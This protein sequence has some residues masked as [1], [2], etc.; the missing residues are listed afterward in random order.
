MATADGPSPDDH[1]GG[2]YWHLASPSVNVSLLHTTTSSVVADEEQVAELAARELKLDRLVAAPPA[3]FARTQNLHEASIAV[4][5]SDSPQVVTA[6]GPPRSGSSESEGSW[7]GPYSSP[8]DSPLAGAIGGFGPTVS[9]ES[10]N[11]CESDDLG[12]S[13]VRLPPLG[14]RMPHFRSSSNESEGPPSRT[15]SQEA[16]RVLVPSTRQPYLRAGDYVRVGLFIDVVCLCPCRL[17]RQRATRSCMAMAMAM[18]MMSCRG[19]SCPVFVPRP[20]CCTPCSPADCVHVD[21]GAK[22]G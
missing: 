4:P 21:Q 1:F 15:T 22:V 3:E 5:L 10:F 7:C 19:S 9:A 14:I 11:S 17:R 2:R 12:V 20:P 16:L 6:G 18:G 8:C 13:E